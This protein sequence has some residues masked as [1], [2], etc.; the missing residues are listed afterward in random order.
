MWFFVFKNSASFGF[1]LP[2]HAKRFKINLDCKYW[3]QFGH[4]HWFFMTPWP[5][6]FRCTNFTNDHISVLISNV[7]D[8]SNQHSLQNLCHSSCA[9]ESSEGGETLADVD[10]QRGSLVC[11][12]H[13]DSQKW[14][15]ATCCWVVFYGWFPGRVRHHWIEIKQTDVFFSQFGNWQV[16]L[17]LVTYFFPRTQCTMMYYGPSMGQNYSS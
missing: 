1:S 12:Q 16:F 7:M 4:V 2:Q 5:S 15:P 3:F 8:W 9:M 11:K 13:F 14:N 10:S 17:F 6:I